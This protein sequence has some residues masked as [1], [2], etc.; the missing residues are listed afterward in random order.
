MGTLKRQALCDRLGSTSHD[1]LLIRKTALAEVRVDGFQ[2][3]AL[4]QGYEVVTSRI[5][6]QILHRSLLPTR[7]DIGE[8]RLEAINTLEVEKQLVLS[9]AMSLQHLEHCRF[10]IVVNSHARHSAPE[11]KGMAPPLCRKASCR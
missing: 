6:D 2:I 1:T 11:L 9:P 10:E 3:N 8:K 7:M 5:A 4:R